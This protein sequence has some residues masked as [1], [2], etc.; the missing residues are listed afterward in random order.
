VVETARIKGGLKNIAVKPCL[1]RVINDGQRKFIKSSARVLPFS[2]PSLPTS[3]SFFALPWFFPPARVCRNL[4]RQ[5]RPKI[6]SMPR[7]TRPC[8][9]VCR[10]ARRARS[11]GI[12][13]ERGWEK[14]MRC[15]Q[16]EMRGNDKIGRGNV[17]SQALS[18][19]TIPFI[20][21]SPSVFSLKHLPHCTRAP[22]S[23]WRVSSSH[24]GRRC[25]WPR[26]W[27]RGQPGSGW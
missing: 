25:C 3:D 1:V 7:R 21:S 18:A 6:S 11:D 23:G 17:Q 13:R 10:G 12:V 27:L 26:R 2:Q 19:A 9:S 15:K 20:V 4:Q 16:K 5:Y 8:P 14:R 24:A 22:P